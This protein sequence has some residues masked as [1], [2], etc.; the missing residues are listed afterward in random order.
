MWSARCLLFLRQ[1]GS[2]HAILEVCEFR[3]WPFN[4]CACHL[5]PR[6]VTKIQTDLKLIC[7]DFISSINETRNRNWFQRCA[8]SD[9]GSFAIEVDI[10]SHRRT[11]ILA[12][13]RL[14]LIDPSSIEHNSACFI[15]VFII[16]WRVSTC[17][18]IINV[19]FFLAAL[20]FSDAQIT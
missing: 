17:C 11:P 10:F 8:K 20:Y 4:N 18:N 13:S 3:F 16:F 12:V 6:I 15:A 19:S 1:T 7:I 9:F 5:F 14:H 2:R